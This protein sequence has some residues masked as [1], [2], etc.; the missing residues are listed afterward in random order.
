MFLFRFGL[1][2]VVGSILLASDHLLGVEEVAVRTGPDLIDDIGLEVNVDR[3]R[4][5]LALTCKL[6]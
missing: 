3:A 6:C 2:T 4:N 1:R 5:I